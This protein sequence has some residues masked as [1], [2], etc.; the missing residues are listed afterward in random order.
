M[1]RKFKSAI[2]LLIS[3]IIW[4][5]SYVIQSQG[6]EKVGTYTMSFTRSFV[7]CCFLLATYFVFKKISPYYKNEVFSW[8]ST[9]LTGVVCGIFMNIG[10]NMQQVGVTGTT[11]GKA[12]FLTAIYIVI[13]PII[14]FLAGK[15]IPL[16][17]F[18]CIFIAMLGTYLLSFRGEVTINKWDLIILASAIFFA[19]HII[20][21]SKCPPDAEQILVSFIQFFTVMVISFVFALFKEEIRMEDIKSAGFAILY[22]GILSSGVGFTV[23]LIVLKDLDTTVVSLISSLESVFAA[24]GGWLLLGQSMNGR[25]IFG[26]IMILFATVFAQLPGKSEKIKVDLKED[27]EI[28]NK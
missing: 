10:L 28:N 24:V 7:A 12:G 3:A 27:I 9:I 20:I 6:M 5:L 16:K 18:F 8:R 1:S 15:K 23:Q 21:M 2:M 17:M 11:A 25:E 13:I 14:E 4:G 19:L 26:C 22:L